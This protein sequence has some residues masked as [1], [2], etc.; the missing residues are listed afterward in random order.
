MRAWAAL[1]ASSSVLY[2]LVTAWAATQLPP[3]GMPLH[4]DAGGTA[5][6]LGSRSEAMTT[7]A[8]LGVVMLGLGVGLVLLA[9]YGPLRAMNIPHKPCWLAEYREPEV[10]RMRPGGMALIIS[11]PLVFLS[12]IPLWTVLGAKAHGDALAP[13]LFGAPSRN[14]GMIFQCTG[15][16]RQGAGYA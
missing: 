12:L 4:F 14:A 11:A 5:D 2:A 16:I 7:S 3:D 15:Q 10:R 9:R 6:R 13:L 8:V 1:L